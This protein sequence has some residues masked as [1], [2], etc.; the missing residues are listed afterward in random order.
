[1]ALEHPETFLRYSQRV[2]E[3]YWGEDKDI[4]KDDVLQGV[5]TEAGLNP[6]EYFDKINRQEYKDRVRVNTDEVMAR[7]GYGTPTIFVN[8]SMFFGNDRLVLVE[9]ELRR[10]QRGK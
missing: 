2:F 7:G 3:S 9:E 10:E 6:Q 1:V 5:V 8:G 4:S